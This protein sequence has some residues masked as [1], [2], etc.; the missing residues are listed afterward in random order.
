[1]IYLEDVVEVVPYMGWGGPARVIGLEVH[2]GYGAYLQMLGDY[3]G[4]VKEWYFPY[5]EIRELRGQSV[6]FYPGSS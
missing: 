4:E 3:S 1:M 5:S 2:D 6:V